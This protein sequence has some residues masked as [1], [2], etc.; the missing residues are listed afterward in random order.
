MQQA[1]RMFGGGG[2][3]GGYFD[4]TKQ[5]EKHNNCRKEITPVLV[6]ETERNRTMLTRSGKKK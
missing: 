3:G 1:K 2:G 4:E 6:V 5:I